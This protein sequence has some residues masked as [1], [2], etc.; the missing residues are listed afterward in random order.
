VDAFDVVILGGTVSMKIRDQATLTLHT[1]D[2]FLIP[3]GIPH[4]AIDIG[5]D[6]GKM[7]SAYI[8]DPSQ[9]VATL[10]E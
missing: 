5:P 1:G 7:I 10:T 9:P 2:G 4:N 6:T 8:V 3:P